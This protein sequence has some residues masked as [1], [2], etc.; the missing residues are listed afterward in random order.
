MLAARWASSSIRP[1]AVSSRVRQKRSSSS[2]RSQSAI[3]SSS[4]ASPRSS[5]STICSSSFCA[6]SNVSSLT[7]VLH[8]G[9]ERAL[10]ELDLDRRAR[11]EAGRG[12]EHGVARADDR[13]AA[14]ERRPR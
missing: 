5:R 13:I 4:S 11:G 6:V 7:D 8:P 9:A 10:G 12:P 1:S 3:A 2:P 14:A